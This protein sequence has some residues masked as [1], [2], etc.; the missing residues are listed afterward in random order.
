[1]DG[2]RIPGIREGREGARRSWAQ[3]GRRTG[4]RRARWP[5]PLRLNED[6]QTDG[7]RRH[8]RVP[9]RGG[10]WCGRGCFSVS[11]TG[12]GAERGKGREGRRALGAA[13]VPRRARP[14]LTSGRGA[15]RLGSRRLGSGSR[16][17]PGRARGRES[18][19]PDRDGPAAG[20]VSPR[21]RRGGGCG[22][23]SGDPGAA[24]PSRA[25]A[26]GSTKGRGGATSP[27]CRPAPPRPAQAPPRAGPASARRELGSRAPPLRG[28]LGLGLSVLRARLAPG[29]QQCVQQPLAGSPF[30]ADAEAQRRGSLPQPQPHAPGPGGAGW[31]S[32]DPGA[33]AW[34]S[35]PASWPASPG[36]SLSLPVGW[37][38]DAAG[39]GARRQAGCLSPAPR[40]AGTTPGREVLAAG[41]ATLRAAPTRSPALP[42][43]C[44]GFP[45]LSVAPS[46]R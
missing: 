3:A 33:H 34:D 38:V 22:G 15:R 35:P 20:E 45:E 32:P 21:P 27:R 18:G 17:A 5:Q 7:G 11:E 10:T 43:S 4:S 1:M 25:A 37:S 29:P 28:S 42:L 39:L 24:A 12:T 30:T 31:G 41:Q 40:R 2:E 14:S 46:R 8:R 23:R 19:G 9:E 36:L 13:R 44:P 26:H 6:R 16:P